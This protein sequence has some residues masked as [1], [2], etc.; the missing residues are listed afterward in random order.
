MSGSQRQRGLY[1]N[2][3]SQGYSVYDNSVYLLYNVFKQKRNFS[4]LIKRERVS[5]TFYFIF[6]MYIDAGPDPDWDPI[7][8]KWK[9]YEKKNR[10]SASSSSSST[11]NDPPPTKS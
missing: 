10:A 6:C 4:F 3:G 8:N 11:P 1:M 9:G 7:T 2:A 5:S